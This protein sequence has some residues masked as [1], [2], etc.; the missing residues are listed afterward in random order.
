MKKGI[1]KRTHRVRK[2]EKE[3]FSG[4]LSRINE[5]VK[6]GRVG[7]N[8][9]Q[10]LMKEMI[11]E[12]LIEKIRLG[13]GMTAREIEKSLEDPERFIEI[14]DDREMAHF[15]LDNWK[16]AAGWSDKVSVRTT[17]KEKVESGRKFM[18]E[19][20]NILTKAEAWE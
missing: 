13:R 10:Y 18:L 7:Y 16:K 14:V 2:T 9:S 6:R 15:I 4:E 3:L 1:Q 20:E 11:A 19:V 5:I 17:D 12:A 8:Y